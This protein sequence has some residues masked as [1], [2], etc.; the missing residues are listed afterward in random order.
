M[1][2][3]TPV[4]AHP[5]CRQIKAFDETKKPAQWPLRGPGYV[6]LRHKARLTG[7]YGRGVACAAKN[8]FAST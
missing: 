2:L 4:L 6:F 7:F 5:V 1:K 3:A 8:L